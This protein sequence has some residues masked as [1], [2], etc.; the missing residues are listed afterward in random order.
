VIK[1]DC[2]RNEVV[3][4]SKRARFSPPNVAIYS[5]DPQFV[6]LDV[7]EAAERIGILK[8]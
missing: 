5:S 6:T 2:H 7:S 1:V 3:S 8:D 4:F